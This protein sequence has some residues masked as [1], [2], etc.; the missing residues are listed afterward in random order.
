MI[1]ACDIGLKRIGI[2]T[3]INGIILPLQPILRKN[4][5]QASKEL[6]ALLISR[7]IDT[8]VIGLPCSESKQCQETKQR[9]LFFCNLLESNVK[10][11]FIDED[12]SSYEATSKIQHLK[13]QKKQNSLKDGKLDSLAACEILRRYLN[14]PNASLIIS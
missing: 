8:L 13:K 5:M 7:Q 14:N 6:D 9:I 4:R 3:C 12:F 10:K 1:L 2:A 11:V